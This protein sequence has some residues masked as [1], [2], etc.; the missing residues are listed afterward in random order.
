VAER[1]TKWR[2][3]LRIAAKWRISVSP[4][5]GGGSHYK[6][7]RQLAD[8]VYTYPIPHRDVVGKPYLRGLRKQFRLTTDDGISDHEFYDA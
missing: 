5:A 8:G 2:D 1:I 3:L 4:P 7:S 6:F